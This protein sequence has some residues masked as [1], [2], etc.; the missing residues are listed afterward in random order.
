MPILSLPRIEQRLREHQPVV[1]DTGQFS[2]Q[3]AVA[4]ILRQQLPALLARTTQVPGV[5]PG[6][7]SSVS[8]SS[9]V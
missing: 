1:L 9:S 3:A 4:A 5:W 7:G 2:R 6:A 8:S